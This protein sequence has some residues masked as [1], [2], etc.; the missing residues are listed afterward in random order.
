MYMLNFFPISKKKKKKLT[1]KTKNDTV[2][3]LVTNLEI[4]LQ[5][6]VFLMNLFK[7]RRGK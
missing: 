3:K 2:G 1:S 6:I 5:F 7:F 4:Y